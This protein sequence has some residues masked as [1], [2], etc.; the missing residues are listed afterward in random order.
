MFLV[1]RLALLAGIVS[2]AAP[3]A[4]A[5]VGADP[6]AGLELSR[7]KDFKAMRSSSNH[8][9]PNSNWDNK[10]LPPGETMVLADLKG[11]GAITHMWITIDAKEYAWP[12]LLRLRIHWDGS[13]FPSVDAPLGDFFGTGLGL[14]RNIISLPVR[15][16]ADGRSLNCYWPMPFREG[17]R[18]TVTNEG[19]QPVGLFYWHVDWRQYDAIPADAAYFHAH[20]RQALPAPPGKNY[21]IA[22]LKGAG[23]YIGT[24]LSVVQNRTGWFG[25]GD[26]MWYVD[27][28]TKASLEGTGT[29]DYFNDAWG[30]REG[31]GPYYGITVADGQ[32]VGA[33]SSA[34][35]W[36]V[37]DPVPF[38]K[39][40]RLEI[41][42]KGWT[43]HDETDGSVRSPFEE[44]A[45]LFSSVA[46]WYQKALSPLP[47]VPSGYE[48][49][50][51]GNAVVL[52]AED[53]F[54]GVRAKDG[55]A[56]IQRE[57]TFT[58]DIVLFRGTGIGSTV[59]FPFK[60]EKPGLYEVAVQTPDSFDY[61]NYQPV[62][63]GKPLGGTVKAF[64]A[65]TSLPYD[66]VLGR[67]RLAAGEHTLAFE[68]VGKEPA[69]TGYFFGVDNIILARIPE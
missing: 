28:E 63:D 30:F 11:A 7:L 10:P 46:F 48:R 36:H 50:P 44:R 69:S 21:V 47:D 51:Y 19:K 39:S 53:L 8:P 31:T 16:S 9:D 56:Q 57:L 59:T 29:E 34:Y 52:E 6:M 2:L 45:D 26:D 42:H 54:S 25:E 55:E 27:G 15:N 14:E 37:P 33:R 43:F 23:H 12:R 1:P 32:G 18:V 49:L 61:G 60:V 5:Q 35:R 67:A 24:V 40:L 41:E 13:P 66:R 68:A 22:D 3:P 20:Y 58:R 38:K 4:I 65:G 64:A 17:A 62:V